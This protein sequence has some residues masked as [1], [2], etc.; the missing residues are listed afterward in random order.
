[1]E[2]NDEDDD[3]VECCCS[4]WPGRHGGREAGQWMVVVVDGWIM[5]FNERNEL[6]MCSRNEWGGPAVDGLEISSGKTLT[7]RCPHSE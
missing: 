2:L 1:M 3:M 6:Y 7:K 5:R 4:C